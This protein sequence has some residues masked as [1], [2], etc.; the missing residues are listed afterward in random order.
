MDDIKE[1]AFVFP[2]QQGSCT[3]ELTSIVTAD[4]SKQR[5]AL[6]S[7]MAFVGHWVRECHLSVT[8]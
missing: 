5:P 6:G 8:L 1:T 3:R 7:L 4:T 2:A